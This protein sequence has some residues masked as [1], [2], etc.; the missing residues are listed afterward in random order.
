MKNDELVVALKRQLNQCAGFEGDEIADARRK[1]LDYYFQ[2]PNGTEVPGRAAVVSGDISAMVE[3]NLAA[4]LEAFENDHIVE[5]DADG[6]EDEEQVQLESDV[7]SHFVMKANSGAYHLGQAIKDALLLR[8]GWLKVWCDETRKARTEEY[9]NVTP[10]ALVELMSRP[11]VECEIKTYDESDGY[12]KL[13][14]VY[15]T[16]RFRAEAVA[17]ENIFYP[18]SYDGADFA[19]IQDIPFIA[20]RHVETRSELVRRGFSKAKVDRLPAYRGD[21]KTDAGARNPA[22]LQDHGP[23]VDASSELVE[24][25]ETYVR[26]DNSGDG[27]AELYKVCWAGDEILKREPASLVPY[28]AG[29]AIIAAHRLTG[30]SLWDKLHQTQDVSTALQRALLDNVSATSKNRLAYLDG[31]ANPDD[32]ADGRVNGAVRVKPNVPRVG[33]AIMP[34]AVPDTSTGVL[35]A[36]QYQNRIRTELGGA[37]LDLQSAEAQISKQVG[38]MGVDRIYSVAE[39]LAAHMTSNIA[40][41]LIRSTF[42]LAHATLREHFEEPVRIKQ[43]GNWRE[44]VPARWPVRERLTVKIGMSPGERARRQAALDKLLQA[45]IA[46]AERGMDEVLVSASGFYSLLMD[47]ARVSDIPS[48]ERYFIDPRSDESQQAAAE[49]ARQ[50]EEVKKQQQ[51]LVAQAVE[52]EKIKTALDKYKSDADR[53]FKYYDAVLSAEIEEAKIAG[54]ATVDLLR[55]K[56][57]AEQANP[58]KDAAVSIGNA[59]KRASDTSDP[60]Y[61]G[62][63]VTF[64]PAIETELGPRPPGAQLDRINPEGGYEPGN[65]RWSTDR[66]P[67]A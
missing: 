51:Q 11:G 15:V 49:K 64:D 42:L 18:K 27:I 16:K 37:A 8:N 46:L 36:I 2:R 54:Q 17:V 7:V 41:T 23:G 67:G 30:I 50:A 47:W 32:I 57:A 6:P 4:M 58:A 63:G 3:A 5:F 25:F 31:K 28:A 13:R 12:L 19:A 56:A 21:T 9:R 29:L 66:G 55:A 35:A 14:C 62:K 60:N 20:E 24:W 26:F 65:V 53:Q 33:D 39:Q 38:S 45:Q 22:S 40:Q 52:L 59:K 10:E 48:P 1:A 43:E 44:A 34:L 61:G